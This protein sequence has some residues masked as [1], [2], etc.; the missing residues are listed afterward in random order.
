MTDDRIGLGVSRD[1]AQ[2]SR[3]RPDHLAVDEA[4]MTGT[5][6]LHIIHS[7]VS[8]RK[9]TMD[10]TE[11]LLFRQLTGPFATRSRC[12][13]ISWDDFRQG[14]IVRSTANVR[15]VEFWILSTGMCR[16]KG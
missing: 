16:C 12:Q 4:Q 15:Q 2:I 7:N 11:P 13:D 6:T 3:Q 5:Q 1:P 8:N 10:Y 14:S 9:L